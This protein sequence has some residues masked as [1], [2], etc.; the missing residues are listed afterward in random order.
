MPNGW[1]MQ[2]GKLLGGMMLFVMCGAT[3]Q[4]QAEQSSLLGIAQ[5]LH[6]TASEQH[7]ASLVAK[8]AQES[9]EPFGL[10]DENLANP[11]NSE[12]YAA[13]V[14]ILLKVLHETIQR[15]P[16][17]QK[18]VE[19]TVLRWNFCAVVNEGDLADLTANQKAAIMQKKAIGPFPAK[20][21][22]FSIWGFTHGDTPNRYVPQLLK[23]LSPFPS[24]YQNFIYKLT[25]QQCFP[26][27]E[28]EQPESHR[29]YAGAYRIPAAKLATGNKYPYTWAE[30]CPDTS[31]P[32][33][34][35]AAETPQPK[36]GN[37]HP[38]KHEQLA[39]HPIAPPA[40]QQLYFVP[41]ALQATPENIPSA[42]PTPKPA[43]K[44]KPIVIAPPPKTLKVDDRYKE[45]IAL[46]FNEYK[47][48]TDQDVNVIMPTLPTP[49]AQSSSS[50]PVPPPTKDSLGFSGNIHHSANLSGAL[51]FG[52]NAN[53]KLFSYASL[54]C[55]LSFA[56]E[57]TTN[58]SQYACYAGY[59][60]WHP[61][62]FSLRLPVFNNT[63]L[64]LKATAASI[65]YQ[66]KSD[67]L[68]GYNLSASANVS[69]ALT[70]MPSIG[71]TWQWTPKDHWYI[72][73]GVQRSLNP[74]GEWSWIYGFGYSDYHPFSWSLTYDN[75]GFN[76]VFNGSSQDTFNFKQNG[77]VTLS[78]SWAF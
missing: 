35:K 23:S 36:I 77:V 18:P 75:W 13:T 8:L 78:W 41:E 57:P 3:S 31:L 11:S 20:Q 73:A 40:T 34:A 28:L 72:R 9:I 63:G 19:K 42:K 43:I 76:P 55:S 66:F 74:N 58:G 16:K 47:Q 46:I 59:Y 32:D 44:T 62:T 52:V 64:A 69:S 53:Y 26:H 29:P 15:F 33:T 67:F 30:Q 27:P 50:A 70:G 68:K 45:A 6:C 65:G 60:D 38:L 5:E 25:Q 48:P 56:Y 61:G 14:D 2:V 12:L 22:G 54:S 17:L 7:A 39:T 71:T 49:S 51:T 21:R 24:A 1:I 37:S 4:V 10:P